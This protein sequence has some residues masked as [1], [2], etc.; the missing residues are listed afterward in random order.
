MR[1]RLH[2]PE[3][4]VAYSFL[5]EFSK[6]D[7][8]LEKRLGDSGYCCG[9]ESKGAQL[10]SVITLG[11]LRRVS[12]KALREVCAKGISYDVAYEQLKGLRAR[13]KQLEVSGSSWLTETGRDEYEEINRRLEGLQKALAPRDYQRILGGVEQEEEKPGILF[14][15][16]QAAA[17]YE[18]LRD[19]ET[20]APGRAEYAEKAIGLAILPPIRRI[21]KEDRKTIAGIFQGEYKGDELKKKEEEVRHKFEELLANIESCRPTIE[22][23]I[24]RCWMDLRA[25]EE[26][27]E[28][29]RSVTDSFVDHVGKI[30]DY[31]NN[32][33]LTVSLFGDCFGKIL[34]E[35]SKAKEQHE[36]KPFSL[37]YIFPTSAAAELH[38]RISQMYREFT[39]DV[40]NVSRRVSR[41][42]AANPNASRKDIKAM[43]TQSEANAMRNA[44]LAIN[45]AAADAQNVYHGSMDE[46][47]EAEL[48]MVA[49]NSAYVKLQELEGIKMP[50]G[51]EE[52]ELDSWLHEVE[53]AV[54]EKK[55]RSRFY[56]DGGLCVLPG[57][58]VDSKEVKKRLREK[59]A[60]YFKSKV[61][62][63]EELGAIISGEVA[64]AEIK[65]KRKKDTVMVEGGQAPP[66]HE[67]FR[68]QSTQIMS[69]SKLRA[70]LKARKAA[71][72]APVKP[73]TPVKAP[74]TPAK[75][76]LL[77]AA[78]EI[79][80][81]ETEAEKAARDAPAEKAV[82]EVDSK[83]LERKITA[84]ISEKDPIKH[85]LEFIHDKVKSAIYEGTE[86]RPNDPL[87]PE[88]FRK[89]VEQ[90]DKLGQVGAIEELD[91]YMALF[92]NYHL[93]FVPELVGCCK[94][95]LSG[96]M[97]WEDARKK[98][99]ESA[100]ENLQKESIVRQGEAW[101]NEEWNKW[102]THVSGLQKVR[103]ADKQMLDEIKRAAKPVKPKPAPEQ[104]AQAPPQEPAAPEQAPEEEED[105]LKALERFA[106][107]SRSKDEEQA[108]ES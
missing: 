66:A 71:Q 64:R 56:A 50:I 44:I 62:E 38:K 79:A 45:R 40:K 52:M 55:S 17:I 26:M 107:E 29:N 48:I 28:K 80:Q 74:P 106:K 91:D 2:P 104:P 35:M 9:Y 33:K 89:T 12:V 3:Q 61:K 87:F 65:N 30:A 10:L 5:P 21:L 4:A 47:T 75:S 94:E 95:V 25:E 77:Q 59:L 67:K 93:N 105:P 41:F 24:G 60:P 20:E 37:D 58:L 39:Q 86:L 99:N 19:L 27:R 23:E 36:T 53:K 31:Y 8:W 108:G 49:M 11:L 51:I 63:A 34:S 84:I 70:Q 85:I 42:K 16:V 14:L 92:E 73:Q 54:K 82:E 68:A 88:S 69:A 72:P 97:T 43:K 90:S 18:I 96:K 32:R 83:A 7:N 1:R 78:Q 102:Y 46:R 6:D 98:A 57:G 22:A 15:D 103:A 100:L 13:K 101:S 76:L 81:E